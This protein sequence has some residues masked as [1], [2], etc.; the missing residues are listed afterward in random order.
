MNVH[1]IFEKYKEIQ[2]IFEDLVSS[3]EDDIDD[4]IYELSK[5]ESKENIEKIY[6]VL[7]KSQKDKEDVKN[8]KRWFHTIKGSV[9]MAGANKAGLV[10]HRLESVMDYCEN[11]NILFDNVETMV[12]IEIEKVLFLLSNKSQKLSNADINWLDYKNVEEIRGD[13]EEVRENVDEIKNIEEVRENK[14]ED[15][16][17]VKIPS[18]ILDRLINE[19][20]E[21]RL[22]R[23]TL[24][25]ESKINK[26]TL[27]EVNVLAYKL[28]RML[29]E[30]EIQEES[31]IQANKD[32]INEMQKEFDPLEFDK[33]TR[34]QELTRFMNETID[35]LNNSV[36]I[37]KKVAKTQEQAISTQSLITNNILN[38]LMKIRLIPIEIINERLYKITRNTSKDL[39]KKVV[40]KVYGEKT[41]VDRFVADRIIT[42]IEHLIRNCIAHGIEFPEERIKKNKSTIGII[43]ITTSLEDNNV[44]IVVEDDGAGI[45]VEKIK[46][47][48]IKRGLI[49]ENVEY[50]TEEIIDLIFQPGFSTADQVSQIAGRGVGM[51]VVKNEIS[52]LGGTVITTTEKDKGTVFKM[53]LP[54]AISSNQAM[55]AE[56]EDKLVA[57]PVLLVS[58]IFSVKKNEIEESYKNNILTYKN[59]T[60]NL[61][62]LGHL[63]GTLDSDKTPKT[64][65]YNTII[66]VSH[67]NKTIYLHVDSIR[68]T[69]EILIKK[70]GSCLAKIPGLIGA[71]IMGDGKQG[72]VV[73]PMLLS[74]HYEKHIKKINIKEKNNESIVV[75]VVDD[76]LTVRRATGKVLERNGYSVIYGK[77]GADALEQLQIITPK[78]ILSDIE[79]PKMDG[80]EFVKNLKNNKKYKDIPIIMIT[81]RTADKHKN[82]ANDLG[83][84]NFLGKPYKEEDLIQ[85]IKE[86]LKQ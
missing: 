73:N 42:P 78:I 14:K 4:E 38:S 68:T 45:N 61:Y 50:S 74:N 57:I 63:L 6:N 47:S 30:I 2:V 56:T 85:S 23:T 54:V 80:F 21:I 5:E 39:N 12:K 70:V 33:Y 75:M 81:S 44:V 40:L 34:M 7:E 71:T 62:Y 64:K 16:Q 18:H 52:S 83:V 28:T 3:T 84:S 77:D 22:T 65:S 36:E 1:E 13:A 53:I 10:M 76:S 59:N 49:K 31:R 79:M 72:L 11:N 41:E 69:S 86:L 67:A 60:H 15:K 66:S 25:N 9:K 19:A 32:K 29:K 35:D 26:K 27:S 58:E 8:L 17:Y 37:I 82:Y 43:K 20:S 48:G 51:D 24:E 55:L 46:E